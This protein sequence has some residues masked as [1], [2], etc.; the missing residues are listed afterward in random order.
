ML[1]FAIL[2]TV[3]AIGKSAAMQSSGVSQPVF[4]SNEN[5]KDKCKD[6]I[7]ITEK[8]Q[9]AGVL[10]GVCIIVE[11][12][13]GPPD[14]EGLQSVRKYCFTAVYQWALACFVNAWSEVK[15]V[16]GKVNND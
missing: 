2:L 15:Q 8:R 13:G 5:S 4:I 3:G 7:V 6:R 16:L 12:E 14:T 9:R 10:K 11:S 1:L